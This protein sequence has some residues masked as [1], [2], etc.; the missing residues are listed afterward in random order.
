MKPANETQTHVDV[1]FILDDG[2]DEI[3][4]GD[5]Q[6]DDSLERVA[7]LAYRYGKVEIRQGA[8]STRLWDEL[9]ALMVRLCLW[10]LEDILSGRSVTVER[11]AEN[12]EFELLA[13]N[14]TV[15]V[16]NEGDRIVAEATTLARAFFEC[17]TRYAD[18]LRR[19]GAEQAV[20]YRSDLDKA[21][22]VLR[23]L[24]A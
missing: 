4:E 8:R 16:V 6:A 1:H 18:L 24:G 5:L 21:R 11:F 10:P 7:A 15:T 14:G 22:D 19:I 20:A 3:L 17:A 13:S 23:R 12:G 9:D 2:D